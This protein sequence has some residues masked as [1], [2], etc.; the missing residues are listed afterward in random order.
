MNNPVVASIVPT[1]GIELDHVPPGGVAPNVTLLPKHTPSGPIMVSGRG[2]TV[3]T[4]TAVQ[5][6]EKEYPM[7]LLPGASASNVPVVASIVPIA[8]LLDDHVPPVDVVDNVVLCPTQSAS[9]P[10]MGAGIG[11]TETS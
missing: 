6:V 4:A 11:S 10:V 7:M 8:G 5:P 3:I 2:F 1:G 9:V